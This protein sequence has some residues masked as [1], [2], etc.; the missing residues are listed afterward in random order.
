VPARGAV[1]E[2]VRGRVIALS[3][4]MA[5]R[6]VRAADSEDLELVTPCAEAAPRGLA[7]AAGAG[8]PRND[9]RRRAHALGREVVSPR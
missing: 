2:E 1:G 6:W 8:G 4:A 3:E 9:P 7:P 5:T